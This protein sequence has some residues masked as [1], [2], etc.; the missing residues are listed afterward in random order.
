MITG[1]V[2]YAAK[3]VFEKTGI[4]WVTTTLAP[5]SFMSAHDPPVPAQAPQFENLRFLGPT[6]HKYFFKFLRWTIRDW[7]APYREFRQGLG[8][9][10]EDD[11]IFGEKF[12]PLLHLVLFSK[13]L[14]ERQPDW[15]ADAVQ[16]GFCFYDG[17]D[18]LGKMPDGLQNF[19]DAGEPPIVFTLGSAAVMD[20]GTF[21]DESLHAAARLNHRSLLIYGVFNEPP[22]DEDFEISAQGEGSLYKHKTT[23]TEIAA[24]PYAPYSLV[25][26]KAACVVHQGGVGTTAQV[27][28][29]GVPHLFMPF[30]HD[31]PDN[32]ARCRRLGVA[33]VITRETYSPDT[34]AEMLKKIL[35]TPAYAQKAA[36]AG[37]IV[38]AERGT[39]EA[40]DAIEAVLA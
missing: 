11:P 33:E 5:V 13:V 29:A 20:A 38:R 24:F 10:P 6:F 32:A 7:Y 21:F 19:L 2:V 9:D 40:C 34:A 25:F 16:T 31:Q 22:R 12:S 3:S 35:E 8:L 37:R 27:L 1:E 36:D 17:K 18:D 14:G 4:K 26:P 23:G 30:S 15:P 28:R 39:E